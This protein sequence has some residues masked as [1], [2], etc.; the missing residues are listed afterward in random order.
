MNTNT[1]GMHSGNN[2]KIID[3]ELV[4]INMRGAEF[5]DEEH[6]IPTDNNVGDNQLFTNNLQQNILGQSNSDPSIHLDP[7]EGDDAARPLINKVGTLRFINCRLRR[8]R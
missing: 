8:N 6:I 1:S 7:A 5:N 3:L 2:R 4:K